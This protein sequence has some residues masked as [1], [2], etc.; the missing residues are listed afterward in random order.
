M[1]GTAFFKAKQIKSFKKTIGKLLYNS[2]YQIQLIY[3]NYE[4]K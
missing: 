3:N 1:N 2:L 4:R